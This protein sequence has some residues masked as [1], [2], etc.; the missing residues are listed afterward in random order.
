VRRGHRGGWGRRKAP[1]LAL[2][3]CASLLLSGCGLLAGPQRLSEDP[4]LTMTVTVP[5]L[6]A[7]G[8]LPARF[9]CY[10]KHPQSPP[11]S[12]SGAPPGTKSLAV[13]VDDSST[14]IKPRVYWIVFDIG[15]DTTDLQVGTP[16]PSARVAQNSAHRADYDPPCP[17][18]AS[19]KYRVTVY[20][21]NTRFGRS[22][23]NRAPLLQAWTTISAHVIGRGE[24]T[25]KALGQS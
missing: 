12:W 7:G 14:P 11:I 3:A 4:P 18:G 9:T 16:P 5:L 13:V 22:L 24:R 19:H 21:L 10:S 15:A 6:T 20:A 1:L 2:A 17:P 23:P 25:V 8:V